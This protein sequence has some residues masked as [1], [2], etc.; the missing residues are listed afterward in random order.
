M[1]SIADYY[2]FLSS[3]QKHIHCSTAG[4]IWLSP[5]VYLTRI[6]FK[7]KKKLPKYTENI[8]Q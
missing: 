2:I 7:K 4:F 3:D 6:V 8:R 1:I 5:L